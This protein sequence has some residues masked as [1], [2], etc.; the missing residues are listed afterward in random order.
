VSKTAKGNFGPGEGIMT[1]T[2]VLLLALV[3]F[4]AGCTTL[5]SETTTSRIVTDEEY[6]VTGDNSY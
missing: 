1:R 5:E 4:C 6:V 2:M 3:L